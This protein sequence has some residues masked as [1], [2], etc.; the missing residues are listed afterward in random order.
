MKASDYI[1]EFLIHKGIT[2]VFGYPGG[3][4]THLMDSL[5]RYHSQ[6][7]THLNYHEQACAMAACGWAEMTGKP[8]V[9]YATSGPGATN[10]L[11][12]IG[13]AYFD[14]VPC[15]FI[16]GQVNTYEQRGNLRV[17]Q[18]GFQETEIARMADPVCKK[19]YCLKDASELPELLE[20]AYQMAAGGRPGPVLL[21]IPMNVFRGE[22]MSQ[23]FSGEKTGRNDIHPGDDISLVAEDVLFRLKQAKRP[24]ILAGHGIQISGQG[25]TFSKLVDILG[26]P[27]VTS[28]LGVDSIETQNPYN[29]NMI[30]AYGLRWSNYIV[31]HSDCVLTL[32]SR[33][34]CRQ[35][36]IQTEWFAP[37]ATILRVDIDR[38][39]QENRL[40]RGQTDICADL[41]QLLPELLHKAKPLCKTEWMK[42]C[43]DLKNILLPYGSREPGNLLLE[44]IGTFV[45][46]D[47]IVTSDVGQN[48]VWTA[49]S[50]SLAAQ[51]R[52]LS[53]GGHGAMG[54][55][56]PAAIGA[57]IATGKTVICITGDGGIQMN[58][59][60]L[61]TVVREQLSV[62][63]IVLNNHALGMIHHFQEMY[64]D[65]CYAQTEASGGYTVP[66]FCAI[67][68]AY[69][70]PAVCTQEIHEIQEFL[71][72]PGPALIEVP[73]PQ[74]T[75]IYPKLGMNK[76]IHMQEPPLDDEVLSAV[77]N[78][79]KRTV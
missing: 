29:F 53:S 70:L 9:A 58:I 20:E 74:S 46:S 41:K 18:K 59:Q 7:S 56:L 42:I 78:V 22:V 47:T 65:S 16:T 15:L 44:R 66:H 49:Q 48:Q 60:E 77:E 8:G 28:M 73:L 57:C 71:C 26:I 54:Y 3:M 67:A 55:S 13:C 30:G 4:V 76:P 63:I 75:Y 40:H 39:E 72:A 5:E 51:Q 25:D 69:G 19:V 17:R 12:G 50:L 68:R 11:T 79:L 32:G 36:G 52:L 45:G 38:G 21:D 31:N 64:F 61:Q 35:T 34:D 10:L 43:Q 24:V 23:H 6:I 62:K 2:D 33:L 27:V 14:S 1:V 37:D